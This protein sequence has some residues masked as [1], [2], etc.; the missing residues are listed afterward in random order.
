MSGT[1]RAREAVVIGAGL[2]GLVAALRLGR[3]GLDVTLVA[4]GDGGLGLAQG[5]IDVLGYAPDRV[6]EP[7][8]AIAGLPPQHPYAMLGPD[9]VGSAVAWLRDELGPELLVGDPARNV[10]LPTAVGALRPTALAQPSMVA[11]AAQGG[12]SFAVVGVR[13]FKDFNADLIAGNLER[14]CAPD[15][16]PLHAAAAWIELAARPGEADPTGLTYARALDDPTFARRFAEAAAAAAREGDVVLL[17]AV[18]G[19][20]RLGVWREVAERIGRPVAEVPVQPPSVPGLRLLAALLGRV[21]AAGVRYVPGSQVTGFRASGRRLSSIT[22]A[23]AGGPREVPTRHVV[24]APGGFESGALAVDSHGAVAER[25]F[26]LPLTADH[27]SGLIGPDYW[28]PQRLFEVG[29]R[30]DGDTR[31]VNTA[32]EP[33]FDNLYA[34]GGLLAGSQRWREKSGDGIAVASG[35]RAADA[36]EAGGAR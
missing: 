33:V 21:K 32:G 6:A 28:S 14:S 22:Y 17:P 36:I 3:A 7:L 8:A 23:A 27:A 10:H 24:Y 26:A 20:R 15:G 13:Q 16:G 1:E 12:R 18:L 25:L 29:V 4:K 9:A 2:A 30:I 19:L 35:V 11:G 5:T 31:P 34:A